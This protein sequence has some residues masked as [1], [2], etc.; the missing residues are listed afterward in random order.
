MQHKAILMQ[1][2]KNN[3]KYNQACWIEILNNS[4]SKIK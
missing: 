1:E 4:S 3:K 2:L